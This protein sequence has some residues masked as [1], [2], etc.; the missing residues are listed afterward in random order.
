MFSATLSHITAEA[1]VPEQLVHYVRAVSGRRAV[2]CEGYPAY[3]HEGGAVLV[4]YPGAAEAALWQRQAE[5][6]ADE[7]APCA[8][9]DAPPV[10]SLAAPLEL[11]SRECSEITVLAP[12]RPLEAPAGAQSR[13]DC[14]WQLPLPAPRAGVKLR[15]MLARAG[16]E[17]SVREEG[18][19]E[20]H[21]GLVEQYLQ[22]R[23]LSPGT[24][25]LF[26]ALPRYVGDAASASPDPERGKVLL[27]AARRDNGALAGLAVGDFS[28]LNTAFYMFAF[29]QQTAPPGTADLL[30]AGLVRRAEELGH[31]R[32]N[33]GLGINAGIGFFKKKWGAV[34]YLPYVETA[35]TLPAGRASSGN[36]TGLLAGLRRLFGSPR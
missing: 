26:S 31:E 13:R 21:A 12:F 14:Y 7:D 30:L 11:L 17:L 32:L 22:T 23:P 34:P 2:L 3:I 25:S 36:G 33:L 20:D 19:A 27:L 28:G 16:H 24:R 6:T 35:W 1:I 18:W 29:R 8:P 15:N 4:A 5:R 10:P 9:E